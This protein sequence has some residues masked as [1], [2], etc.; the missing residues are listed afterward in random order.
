MLYIQNCD[1][2]R[3]RI[4]PRKAIKSM[5]TVGLCMKPPFLWSLRIQE[6]LYVPLPHMDWIRLLRIH[7]GKPGKK[8]KCSLH[9]TR[10]DRSTPP[11]EALSYVWLH[12]PGTQTIICN[13]HKKIV[14][15]NLHDALER[16]RYRD[17]SRWLWVDNVCIAQEDPLEKNQQLRRMNHVYGRA[18]KVIVW[19]GTDEHDEAHPTF[20]T[21]CTLVNAR[22]GGG[23]VSFSTLRG[24]HLY[25]IPCTHSAPPLESNEWYF[26]ASFFTNKWWLRMWVLQEIVLAR[27]ATVIWGCAEV[28]WSVISEAIDLIR[29]DD[30][31]Y[32]LL[33]SRALQNGHV[34]NS[35]VK[36]LGNR[37][38]GGRGPRPS[39]LQL[40]D[41]ARSFD[42]TLAKD[43]I[44]G[45]LG[46]PNY[47]DDEE[48]SESESVYSI[49]AP[50]EYDRPVAEIYTHVARQILL[51]EGDLNLLG[52]TSHTDP[53]FSERL[54][55]DE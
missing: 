5:E 16:L 12:R 41:V 37:K 22:T 36:V 26:V 30:Y 45:L 15:T 14:P 34:M 33:E 39:F 40:L 31:L 3:Q 48:G 2:D 54:C 43:K 38:E 21:L 25:C 49:C 24:K 29:Q 46:F 53:S 23:P 7:P 6:L 27:S 8:I 28:D 20:A 10:L 52:Y 35:L 47:G 32:I 17:K 4:E 55:Q 9:L 44:Y 11:Y 42:V 1:Q 19:L 50:R 51:R 13:G 18:S